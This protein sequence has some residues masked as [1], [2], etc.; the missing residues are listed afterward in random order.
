M[1]GAYY[2][3]ATISNMTQAVQQQVEQFHTRQVKS[4]YAQIFADATFTSERRYTIAKEALNILVGITPENG[5][6]S[7]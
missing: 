5:Q 4:R 1:Y 6:R 2:T 7:D 3:K